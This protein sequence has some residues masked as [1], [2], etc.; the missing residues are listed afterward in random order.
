M[1]RLWGFAQGDRHLV[2]HPLEADGNFVVF[3]DRGPLI[4]VD[5]SPLVKREHTALSLVDACVGDLLAVHE[6]GT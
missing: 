1:L 3:G 6:N 2:D 4:A 5:V